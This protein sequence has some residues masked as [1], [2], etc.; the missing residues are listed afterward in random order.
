VKSLPFLL[1]AACLLPSPAAFAQGKT[2][3]RPAY[4]PPSA[5]GAAAKPAAP[6]EPAESAP[7][8]EEP[9]RFVTNAF[10]DL[11]KVKDYSQYRPPYGTSEELKALIF[12]PKFDLLP[13]HPVQLKNEKTWQEILT[14]QNETGACILLRFVQTQDAPERNGTIS[15]AERGRVKWFASKHGSAKLWQAATQRFIQVDVM[16]PGN[17][18]TKDFEQRIRK[19]DK[20]LFFVLRPGEG[21]PFPV[22][23]FDYEP[24]TK[25]MTLK[26]LEEDLERLKQVATPP[27]SDIRTK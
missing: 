7:A 12:S 14:L 16:L 17:D 20:T 1:L 3:T 19:G 22:G 13:R 6:A 9:P 25:K 27:Y 11:V 21:H 15:S 24:A 5:R 26:P 4:V 23:V 2:F 18:F 8:A 10:G